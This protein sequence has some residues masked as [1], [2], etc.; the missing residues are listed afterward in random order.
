MELSNTAIPGCFE[1]RSPVFRDDRGTFS[2]VFH[3]DRFAQWGLATEFAEEYYS[4]SR[5][6]VLR[7]MHFQLP[8]HEHVKLV[9]CAVRKVIDVVVDLRVGSPMYGRHA[10]VDLSADN[11]NAMYIPPGV[12]HGFYVPEGTALMVYKVTSLYAP[13]H[14]AGIR[15]DSAGIAW[16]VERPILSERDRGFSRLDDFHSQFTYTKAIPIE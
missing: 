15:W 8:P 11:G 1:I 7:G 10:S 9:Y 2:K 4:V 13:Q 6:G 5:Q 14:D 3:R 16:P 12:A